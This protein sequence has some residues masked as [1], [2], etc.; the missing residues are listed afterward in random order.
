MIEEDWATL[1]QKFMDLFQTF[2][3]QIE[4]V[5][6]VQIRLVREVKWPIQR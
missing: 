2:S 5:H 3:G 6:C 1:E 4:R